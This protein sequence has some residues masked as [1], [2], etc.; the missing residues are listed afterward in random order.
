MTNFDTIIDRRNTNSLKYDFAK[1]RKRPEDVLPLWV[2]DMDFQVAEPILEAMKQTLS[3]GIFGYS[4]AK[5]DYFHS[6]HKWVQKHYG[7]DTKADWLIKTP[8]I[9]YAI[10]MAIQGLTKEGDAV[11]IQQPVYYPFSE[12]VVDNHRKLVNN[13]LVYENGKYHIDYEDFERKIVE[14][15]V[16]LFLL[17]NPHNP[18]GRVWTKEELTKLTNI[19]LA[20]NVIIL[21]DEIHADFVYKGYHHTNLAT[22]SKEVEQNV[23]VCTSPTKTFNIAGLQISNIFIPNE[24]IRK[25]FKH[26][27][28]AS[29]YSQVNTFGLVACKAAY[30]KGEEWLAELKEYL[31]GNLE[32]LRDFFKKELPQLDLIEPEGT[33]LIWFDCS[34]LNL[35]AKGLED[36]IVNR[37]KLWLDRGGMF[38]KETVQFQRINIACPRATLKQALEQLKK[39]IESL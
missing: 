16:K 26:A 39:G 8:G 18:V 37:S 28:D 4:E 1:E 29:G 27:V 20:H 25:K 12:T 38:G 34:R 5:E 14:N 30:D 21:S 15:N 2:A 23:I 11:L 7:W 32:F 33:Y 35:T 9:V 24:E 17:C 31:Q 19:C 6:V 10:A 36:L 22:L 3:H 13:Q